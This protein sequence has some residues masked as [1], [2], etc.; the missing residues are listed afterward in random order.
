MCCRLSE[1]TIKDG[2]I[3]AVDTIAKREEFALGLETE[4]G[5][6]A[7][8]GTGNLLILLGFEAASAVDEAASRFQS[9]CHA[10][11]HIALLRLQARDR[12][13]PDAPTE[14]DAS[15]HDAGVGA[16]GIDQDA[17]E[18]G[19]QRIGC[20]AS[21][22]ACDPQSPAVVVQEPEPS[23]GGVLGYDP[24]LICHALRDVHGLASGRGAGVQNDIA[25]L[26]IEGMDSPLTRAAA[27]EAFSKPR[28]L[29]V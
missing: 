14:I 19:G 5:T 8:E 15:P 10:V 1:R 20:Q 3:G 29:S 11:Q 24:A 6:A 23:G 18:I 21:L 28:R 4:F 27:P 13:R 22:D 25:G 26:G 9:G 17:I 2:H 7:Q 16:G 12:L